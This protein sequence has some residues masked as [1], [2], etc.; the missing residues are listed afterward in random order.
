[1][2]CISGKRQVFIEKIAETIGYK[3]GLALSIDDLI[4]FTSPNYRFVF[5]GDPNS[6]IRLRA[7]EYD[8]IIATLLHG[9]GKISS[10][11]ISNFVISLLQKYGYSDDFIYAM[12]ALYSAFTTSENQPASSIPMPKDL[13]GGNCYDVI[14]RI[15]TNLVFHIQNSIRDKSYE[16]RNILWMGMLKTKQ[17]P[18]RD[19]LIK[20]IQVA[21]NDFIVRSPW[22][23]VRSV[24]WK[25]MRPMVELFN[26]EE[27]ESFY[28]K[29]F[30]QRFIDFLSANSEILKEIHWRQFEGLVAEF[31]HRCGYIVRIGKGRNDDGIDIRAWSESTAR[32]AQ[33]LIQCKRQ[34][35]KVEKTIVK[36]LWADVESEGA[37]SGLIVTTAELSPGARDTIT[38]RLY[39]IIERNF[40]DLK[41]W[42]HEMRTPWT[43]IFFPSLW[44]N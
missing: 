41:K 22:L 9:L 28:G 8:A 31:L 15:A 33:I 35:D 7:E 23:K 20:D 14:K 12:I 3:S 16:D 32:P 37:N 17:F 38:T 19:E 5:E 13:I 39:P 11:D 21:Q 29:F 30:D 10:E 18:V 2:G 6:D 43:G 26:S 34:K 1:M 24:E 25:N 42:L 4:K 36:S 27:I 40:D 44:R